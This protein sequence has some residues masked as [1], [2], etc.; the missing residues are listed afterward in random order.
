MVRGN[1]H[2]CDKSKDYSP[3]I[4]RV[5]EAVKSNETEIFI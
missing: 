1:E 2:E 4:L 3:K 5:L